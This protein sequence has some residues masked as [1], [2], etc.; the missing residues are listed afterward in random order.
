MRFDEG[1]YIGLSIGLD[2]LDALREKFQM[3]MGDHEHGY[4]ISV[5]P[6]TRRSR[7]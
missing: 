4:F 5:G 6:L 1:G 7:Q 2:G 3:T